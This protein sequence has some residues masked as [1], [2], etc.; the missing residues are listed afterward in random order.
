[1]AACRDRCESNVG[2]LND[3]IQR[4]R[5]IY[6]NTGV[7]YRWFSVFFLALGL[8]FML[9]AIGSLGTDEPDLGGF[10]TTALFIM[11]GIG[12]WVFSRRIRA[13]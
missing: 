4:N 11:M 1:M 12:M 10:V 8:F 13:K 2:A 3:L 7:A 6:Q 9:G 5:T